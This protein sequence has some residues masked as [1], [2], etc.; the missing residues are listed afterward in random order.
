MVD[1]A[2]KLIQE[3]IASARLAPQGVAGGR[4]AAQHSS[5]ID[6]DENHQAENAGEAYPNGIGPRGQSSL[7]AVWAGGRR[8]DFIGST[9]VRQPITHIS[10]DAAGKELVSN[11]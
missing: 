5:R 4:N 1:I 3:S 2:S 10:V 6:G 8:A 11:V 7:D 9:S